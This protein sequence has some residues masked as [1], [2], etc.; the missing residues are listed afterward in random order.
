MIEYKK[1]N[2]QDSESIYA[3]GKNEFTWIFEKISWNIELVKWFLIHHNSYCFM[4][5]SDNEI[6]GFQLSFVKDSIGYLGW[7]CVLPD[8]RKRSIASTLLDLTIIEMKKDN[9][10]KN[11][12]SHARDDGIIPSFLSRRGFIAIGENKIEMKLNIGE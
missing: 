7:S 8:Y 11:I 6:V 3:L 9:S 4:A 10:I 12:Y 5:Q 2:L 1:P